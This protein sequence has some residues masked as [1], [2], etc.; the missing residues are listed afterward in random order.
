M[1]SADF[2]F[3]ARLWR[4]L[5]FE[6]PVTEPKRSPKPKRPLSV[7]P[8]AHRYSIFGNALKPR[9]C[10]QNKSGGQNWFSRSP[11]P[12]PLPQEKVFHL[13]RFNPF[14]HL[15]DP[16]SDSIVQ[17]RWERFSLSPGE[18]AGVRASN[19][20]NLAFPAFVSGTAAFHQPLILKT[21]PQASRQCFKLP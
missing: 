8:S 16:S 9:A 5:R 20:T 2:W 14:V 21:R 6:N 18:R 13:A 17:S 10:I 3:W 4:R 12:C 19:H 1:G 15:S 7:G 11:S